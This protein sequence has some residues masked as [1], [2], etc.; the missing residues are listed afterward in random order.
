VYLAMMMTDYLSKKTGE[1]GFHGF[2]GVDATSDSLAISAGRIAHFL[3]VEGPVV[4][5]DTACSGSMVALHLARQALLSGDC[6]AALVAGS[7]ALITPNYYVAFAQA[8]MLS[9]AGR[10]RPFDINADGFVRSEGQGLIKF[11]RGLDCW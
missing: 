2:T 9:Q 5:L 3:G 6:D 4:T 10:S 11:R 8:G 1:L 7:N